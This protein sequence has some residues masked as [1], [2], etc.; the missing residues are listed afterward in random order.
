M[1]LNSQGRILK[2]CSKL[3]PELFLVGHVAQHHFG[4][5][6]KRLYDPL[7]GKPIV[8][9]HSLL[10]REHNIRGTHD[11]KMLRE[12]SHAHTCRLRK[13]ANSAFSAFME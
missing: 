7:I 11:R 4:D 12:I 3:S 2:M 6:I 10:A 1:L 8:D 13:V 5:Q 9:T